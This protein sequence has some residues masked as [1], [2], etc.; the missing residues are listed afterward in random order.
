LVARQ[1]G[2]V[3]ENTPGPGSCHAELE[4]FENAA[5]FRRLD[6]AAQLAGQPVEVELDGRRRGQFFLAG[7]R[8]DFSGSSSIARA[9]ARTGV[10]RVL[11]LFEAHGGVGAQLQRGRGLADAGGA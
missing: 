11:R 5:D 9:S 10:V 2:T 3:T 6:G 8:R 4:A 7:C 1:E